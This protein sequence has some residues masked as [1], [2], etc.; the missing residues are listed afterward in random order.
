V[1]EALNERSQDWSESFKV[2][3][4]P[5]G[6]GQVGGTLTIRRDSIVFVPAKGVLRVSPL[7]MA[8][9]A[10]KQNLE[11]TSVT[12]TNVTGQWLRVNHR[13]GLSEESARFRMTSFIPQTKKVR[14]AV[15]KVQ[16]RIEELPKPTPEEAARIEESRREKRLAASKGRMVRGAIA[17]VI[18]VAITSATYSAASKGGGTYLV[19]YGPVIYGLVAFFGGLFGW[20]GNKK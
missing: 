11:M 2:D 12:G 10:G 15:G 13:V 8:S 9:G 20:L 5:E 7:A 16:E 1:S 6:G 18:G 4:H 19:F 14:A 17:F 3:Y